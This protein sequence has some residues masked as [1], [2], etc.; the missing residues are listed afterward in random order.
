MNWR[1]DHWGISTVNWP[2]CR[3]MPQT[4]ARD[5]HRVDED[6]RNPFTAE[7]GSNASFS[8]LRESQNPLLRQKCSRL[9]SRLIP[10]STPAGRTAR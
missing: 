4:G 10:A 5:P 1:A 3:F 6:S 8:N 2:C 7:R 9:Y